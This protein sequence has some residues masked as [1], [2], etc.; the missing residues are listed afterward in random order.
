MPL[1]ELRHYAEAIVQT[2]RQ[3]LVVLDAGFRMTLANRA[4]YTTFAVREQDVVGRPLFD[5]SDG[6]WDIPR[7]HQ[8]L[9][10]LLPRRS[11][12]EDFE[13]TVDLAGS[14]RRTMLLNA[15]RLLDSDASAPL[16]LLA[17]EDVTERRRAEERLAE[18]AAA[19]ARSNADLERYAYVASHDLQEPLRMVASYTQLLEKRYRGRLDAD[20]DEFIRF[21]V[22]GASRMKALIN[23]LLAYSRLSNGV[24]TP[25]DV[26][27]EAVVREACD[28]L[29]C[30]IKESAAS[31]TIGPLPVVR[32][33]RAQLG[34]LFQNLIA[35]AIKFR[36]AERSPVIAV[37][38]A[39]QA[40]SW[41][42]GVR[43]NGIGVAPEQAERIFEL[44]Q[45]LHTRQTYPGTGI[46]LAI[47]RRIV[48][49]HGG[50]IW[51]ESRPERGSTLYF[52]LPAS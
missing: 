5:L 22:D 35:N 12:L 25:S 27:C 3:P 23:D 40:T 45:R 2:V 8:L 14:G 39:R 9:E 4:F 19:L 29:A 49:H 21:A 15:C 6:Q 24:G 16:I 31:V 11:S 41:L 18:N 28:N 51:I 30:A 17:I 34:Q 13:V 38:A 46:G 47:C 1:Q 37:S 42:I 20:A 33:D 26:D 50:R 10:E 36:D 44:F 7:L 43:D 32:G 52:T 48:E